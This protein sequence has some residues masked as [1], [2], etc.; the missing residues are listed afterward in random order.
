MREEK[1][2]V[3]ECVEGMGGTKLHNIKHPFPHCL[4]QSVIS[5][6]NRKVCTKYLSKKK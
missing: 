3:T 2:D 6:I 4:F 1:R 5:V